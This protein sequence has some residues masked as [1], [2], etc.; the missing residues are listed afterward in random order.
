MTNQ[1][2][3][4]QAQAEMDSS[5]VRQLFRGQILPVILQSEAAECGLACLAMCASYFG[6]HA[7]LSEYRR[8]FSVSLKG[9]NLKTLIDMA[10]V[11]GLTCRPI[12]LDLS[13][14]SNLKTPAILH[15][16]LKHFVVLKKVKRN[17]L[18]IHDP[19]RGE[20][21]FIF[22]DVSRHFTGV[23]L[24]LTPTPAFEKR[25]KIESVKLS[26]LFDRA[27]GLNAIIFQLFLLALVLQAFGLLGPMLNQTIIDDVLGRGD[28]D[29]LATIAV[30]MCIL[31]LINTAVTRL[32]GYIALYMN[33]QL[34]YQM[35]ANLLRHILRLPV[36]WFEKRHIGDILA[37]FGSLS[38]AQS[39]MTNLIPSLM[40]DGLMACFGLIMSL[41][42]APVL[43]AIEIG[44]IIFFFGVRLATFP[45]Y[46][47]RS[48]EGIHLS[49]K[50][51]S[52]FMET[53]RG[54]RTF[55]AFGRESE[56]IGV[57]QNEQAAVINNNIRVARFNLWVTSGSG[58]LSGIQQIIVW[59]IGAK[60]VIDGRLTI[61][62]LFAYQS[63]SGQFTGAVSNLIGSYFNYRYLGIHLERLADIAHADQEQGAN[64][65]VQ[66]EQRFEGRI[67]VRNLSFR[68]AEHEPWVIRDVSFSIEPGEY[69]CFIG[70]SGQGK[71]TLLKLLLGFHEPNEG[72]IRI[73]GVPMRTFGIRTYRS[74]I[75][76]VLQDD[77]LFAGTIADNIAFFDPDIDMT[78]VE[79][80]GKLAA[81]HDDIMTFP[82]G[83]MSLVGDM[84][85]T[86]SG[87]QKQRI[88]LARALYRDPV[89][90]FLDEGTANLDH[91][92]ERC[93]LDSIESLRVTRVVIAHRDA[94]INGANRVVDLEKLN[95]NIVV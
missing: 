49:A 64:D 72:E 88:F 52:T 95:K 34:S 58:I 48:V 94:V 51:Q 91:T 41:L 15:W 83:Y 40:L 76:V 92:S 71:S 14:L 53:L 47:R 82:M 65:P 42:Y 29:L 70:P 1:N 26:N 37:R 13:N 44:T 60:M 31:L 7:S 81:V 79:A 36:S 25:D 20:C 67:E 27:K 35:Q 24:E 8:R 54:A 73:D 87:G 32:R 18:I 5:T 74:R 62:M 2:E 3:S 80:A 57:W 66:V 17:S 77:R 19:A 11:I 55:K 38:N 61:G 12:R 56:R 6:Y 89:I 45:F 84:G 59:Y 46:R 23:A 68:Y 9:T 28:E 4:D 33:T 86:L 39:V 21:S 16:D 75:G 30:G 10:D 85:S 22:E 78:K 50:L 43:T 69:V 93:V 63:Y 90:L